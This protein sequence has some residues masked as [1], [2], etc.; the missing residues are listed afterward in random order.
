MKKWRRGS[1]LSCPGNLKEHVTPLIVAEIKWFKSPTAKMLYNDRRRHDLYTVERATN[2]KAKG[3]FFG[4][5]LT[6]M[7]SKEA[8]KPDEEAV[9]QVVGCTLEYVVYMCTMVNEVVLVYKFGNVGCTLEYVVYMCTMVNE[10]VL[11]YKFGNVADYATDDGVWG[12]E[13]RGLGSMGRDR[14]PKSPKFKEDEEQNL[15]FPQ[16]YTTLFHR[17]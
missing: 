14:S 11:V 6:A 12:G 15:R 3:D 10:V 13:R 9:A 1:E 4:G 8:A 16:P 17:D 5:E 2:E 7:T